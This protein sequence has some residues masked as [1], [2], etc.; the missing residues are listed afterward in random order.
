MDLKR[1]D[2]HTIE[3]DET[4]RDK[5]KCPPFSLQNPLTHEEVGKET[6]TENTQLTMNHH[7]TAGAQ[8][9]PQ[10]AL[11]EAPHQECGRAEPGNTQLTASADA[12]FQCWAPNLAALPGDA[13]PQQEGAQSRTPERLTSRQKV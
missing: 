12:C 3:Q 1:L 11:T 13:K 8:M 9:Q 4:Y 7:R 6:N 10:E 2:R 5:L